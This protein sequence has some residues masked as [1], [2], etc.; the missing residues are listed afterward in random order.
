M[1]LTD[2]ADNRESL[3]VFNLEYS[4]ESE[5][6]F[7]DEP[8]VELF[9][10][11][12]HGARRIVEVEGFYPSFYI[13]EEEFLDRQDD[14]LTE[15]MAREIVVREALLDE[16]LEMNTAVSSTPDAPRV[17]LDDTPLVKIYTVKP[18]QVPKLRE[19]FEWTGEADVFFTNRFLVDT[20]IH[21]GVSVPAGERRVSVDEI[22][23]LDEEDVPSVEPRMHTVDIEVWTGGEFPDVMNPTKPVTAITAHDSYEDSYFCGVLNPNMVAEGSDNTW[24]SSYEWEYPD[25][26]SDEQLSV[27]VYDSENALLADYFEFV[28]ATDP[29]LLT[30]WNSSR[31][32]I[33]S[34]FDY[35][36]LINRAS[37]INEWS[38]QELTYDNGR[39]FVTN[40]GAPTV[41]GRE[42][43]D[44]LQAYKKTQIHE[45][46]SYALGAIAED[47]LGYGKED[48]ADLDEGWLHEPV[49]FMKYNIRDVQAVVQ[50]EAAQNILPLYDHIRSVAGCTYTE[51][52]DSN[53]GIIDLL[54]LRRAKEN[55]YALPTSTKPD[56]QHYWGAYVFDP[57]PGVHK[58]VVYPD[59][60]CFTPDHDVVTPSGV[61]A[62]T[63]LEKGD[64]VYSI[65]PDTGSVEKKPVVETYA[66]PEYDGPIHTFEGTRVNMSV[67]PNHRM[68]YQNDDEYFFEEAGELSGREQLPVPKNGIDADGID[69]VDITNHLE[70]DT[71]DV[72]ATYSEHG[73]SYRSKLP[74][75]CEKKRA[76]YHEGFF[77]SGE[78]FVEHQTEIERLSEDTALSHPSGTGSTFRPYLFDGDTFIKFLG[79]FITEGSTYWPEED[80]TCV[81]QIAQETHS[82]KVESVL[83]EMDVQYSLSDGAYTIGSSIYGELLERLCGTNS[84]SKKIPEFIFE[85]ASVRQKKL[86]L[87]VMMYGD[88]HDAVYYTSSSQLAED[89]VRLSTEVGKKAIHRTR[90]DSEHE[91]TITET[92]DGISKSMRTI[93]QAENGVYC[94][95]VADN[96]TMLV[97]RDGKYQWCGNSLYPN[98]FRDMNVSQET[99]IGYEDALEKSQ[100]TKEDCHTVYVD[101]RDESTKRNVDEPER[102]ELFVLKPSVK[103][104]FIREIVEELI[105]LKYEYKK[106]KYPDTAYSA[107]KRITNSVYGIAGDSVSYG[108]GFR[109]F[110]W[111]IAEAITLAGRDVIKH[112]ANEFQSTVNDMGY[113][114]AEII[115]GDTDSAV[116]KLPSAEGMEETLDVSHTAAEHVDSTYPE[117]MKNRF[118]IE[119]GNMQVEI[120]SYSESAFFMDV[121]K[122]YAQH[123]RWDEG[124]YVD[125][126]E[127]KGFKLVRSDSAYITSDV[128]EGV[129]ERILTEDEPRAAVKEYL[130]RV[131]NNALDGKVDP[132][133]IGIPS[134]ISSDPMDYGWSE[135]DD[136]GETKYFTPQP[137]IRGARYATTYIDG[138]DIGSGAKPL[139]FYV[140]GVV[141]SSEYPEVYDYEDE[142]SL[143]APTDTPDANRREMK[144]LDKRVDAI[145]VEDPSNI[146]DAIQIDWEK[147]AEKTV[148][149]AVDNIV[150]TMGWSFDDLVTAGEQSGLAQFM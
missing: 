26:V 102:K 4:I 44:M 49:E 40:R 139:M 50:I 99:I 142:F 127:Y 120:E 61:V 20:G 47:E 84:F 46:R 64:I 25:G 113:H 134:S 41:D 70:T 146:P 88:G 131:Y 106:D 116:C 39:V 105:D 73:H 36:Y 76:N 126:I 56:V 104:S 13:T 66:Y 29:D 48:V 122:K 100:Y 27:E 21:R 12:E 95:E 67:T 78:T 19:E 117:Y 62:I 110:D 90:R 96:N 108:V 97:G 74:D 6:N 69:E 51:A 33:G 147:M 124:D 94:A 149:D 24:Q 18:S 101:P 55:G 137:H 31:N 138:E 10:R 43:F 115:A 45:K 92:K 32:D 1:A 3:K 80:E 103:E 82:D 144:E 11:D 98:L 140:K 112:T 58:N 150:Q 63:D 22:R 2:I 30:G 23:P 16:R 87:E 125:E 121:K 132:E 118:G 119:D 79:W 83:N 38:Y 86:L 111:R 109:L 5:G 77:F 91:I 72:R 145:A 34:G 68:L 42:T 136:T 60:K 128:Q 59:L 129:L 35:P 71:F 8:I 135:D 9:C 107:V 28:G 57:V 93:E 81:V 133:S 85:K 15:S 141:G 130:K 65:N 89:V 114:D 148:E 52:S 123:V 37:G 75:G 7:I 14:L 53:I 143:N 17:R 54:F